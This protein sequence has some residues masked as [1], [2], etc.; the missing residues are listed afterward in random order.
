MCGP[1]SSEL[2]LSARFFEIGGLKKIFL[3]FTLYFFRIVV[4][5]SMTSVFLAQLP[6]YPATIQDLFRVVFLKTFYV[7]FWRREP[8]KLLKPLTNKLIARSNDEQNLR[9]KRIV[10]GHRI[11]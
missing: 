11:N 2:K 8:F 6:L 7:V 3:S 9:K 1:F 5:R 10:V 4:C